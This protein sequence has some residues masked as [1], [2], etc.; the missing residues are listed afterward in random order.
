MKGRSARQG[1]P[2]STRYFISME[3]NLMLRYNLKQII[4]K[5]HIPNRQVKP[6]VSEVV[7]KTIAHA[8]RIIEGQNFE[9]RKN[10]LKYSLL[11]EDQRKLIHKLRRDTLFNLHP[12]ELFRSRLPHKY[13]KL[14]LE[15]GEKGVEQ[16]EKQITLYYINKCWAEYLDYICYLKESIHLVNVGNKQPLFEFN[17]TIIESFEVFYKDLKDE[18]INTLKSAEITKDGVDMNKEGLK[19]PTST[20]TYLINDS[21]E[22]VGILPICSNTGAAALSFYMVLLF[23]II[24]RFFVKREKRN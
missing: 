3:D 2:G 23:G 5:K 13:N 12:L 11:F 17:K 10:L 24:N 18:I 20:W 8:Q 14:L 6:I 21:A 19:V 15:V 22:N 7:E 1:D 16:A 9:I 4:S